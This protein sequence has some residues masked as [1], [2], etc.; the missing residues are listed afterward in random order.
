V[1]PPDWRPDV[2]IPDD[3]IEDIGRI[4]GYENLPATML[5]GVLPRGIARALFIPLSLAV[6]FAMLASYV[7][8]NTVVPVL[9]TGIASRPLQVA[10]EEGLRNDT[11]P[12]YAQ[13]LPFPTSPADRSTPAISMPGTCGIWAGRRR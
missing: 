13:T 1:R 2:S 9:A 3:V 11:A 10:F 6:G 5:R 8:S 7:L 4:H 12:V